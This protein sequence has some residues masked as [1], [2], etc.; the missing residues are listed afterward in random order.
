MAFGP[1]AADL[2]DLVNWH[3][4]LGSEIVL[5]QKVAPTTVAKQIF[6]VVFETHGE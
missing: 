3:H 6:E 2:V 1:K 4:I 5:Y